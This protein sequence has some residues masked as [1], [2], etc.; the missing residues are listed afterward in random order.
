MTE[1]ANPPESTFRISLF[2]IVM[3]CLGL[4]VPLVLIVA[5]WIHRS[6]I[7]YEEKQ[8]RIQSEQEGFQDFGKNVP[9]AS[10]PLHNR[11]TWEDGWRRGNRISSEKNARE[12]AERTVL[13]E[14]QRAEQDHRIQLEKRREVWKAA[15]EELA[16]K[17]FYGSSG[18][19]RLA[20]EYR[21]VYEDMQVH[22]KGEDRKSVV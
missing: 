21:D 11:D 8:G 12:N 22:G 19:V 4:F 7:A 20:R 15:E 1:Q 10:A 13:V 3:I 18:Y 17:S 9:F 2:A 14:K 16:R 6:N 5:I